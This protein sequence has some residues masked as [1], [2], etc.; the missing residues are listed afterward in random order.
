MS[1]GGFGEGVVGFLCVCECG[2]LFFVFF[3]NNSSGG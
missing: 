2:V 3:F 1:G